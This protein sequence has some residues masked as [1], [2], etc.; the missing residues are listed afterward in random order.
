M[1]LRTYNIFAYFPERML[2]FAN[3]TRYIAWENKTLVSPT[4][5]LWSLSP[6]KN[7]HIDRASVTHQNVTDPFVVLSWCWCLSTG[8]CLCAGRDSC[9]MLHHHL[10]ISHSDHLLTFRNLTLPYVSSKAFLCSLICDLKNCTVWKKWFLYSPDML[11]QKCHTFRNC[12]Q[13]EVWFSLSACSH[14]WFSSVFL[15]PFRKL[16]FQN[17]NFLCVFYYPTVIAV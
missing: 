10:A 2:K 12:V 6:C 5:C 3:P 8:D 16:H 13:Y 9:C 17:C 15:H 1:A 7:S 14:S 4:D 11:L